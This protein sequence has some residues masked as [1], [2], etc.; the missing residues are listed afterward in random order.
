[1]CFVGFEQYLS[2]HFVAFIVLSE[3]KFK[4]AVYPR[5][6]FPSETITSL[7]S[8]TV[9]PN[10]LEI[11]SCASLSA[12]QKKC[13][14]LSEKAD[15]SKTVQPMHDMLRFFSGTQIRNVA[16]LGGNL[17]TASP[18]SDM[19]PVLASLNATLVLSSLGDDK[20]TVVRRK[21]PVSEFFMKYRTV[22][23]KPTEVVEKI[24]IPL[25]KEIFEYAMPFKQARRREDDIR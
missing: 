22:N 16:C 9:N 15:L 23:L 10:H 2:S 6:L 18:I 12:I 21:V 3:T 1:M 24:E 25:V 4:H 7:F 19:N 11:G 5:L 13:A 17:V 20:E 14:G 8:F